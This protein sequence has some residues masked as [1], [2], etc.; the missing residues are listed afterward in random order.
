MNYVGLEDICLLILILVCLIVEH[1]IKSYN[2]KSIQF[3]SSGAWRTTDETPIKTT[4]YVTR[5][6]GYHQNLYFQVIWLYFLHKLRIFIG[7]KY[8]TFLILIVL[9]LNNI[10]I[11]MIF[12]Q[13]T[14]FNFFYILSTIKNL[15]AT[16][17][18]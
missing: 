8:P 15:L 5:E 14:L 10:I 17:K 12:T 16:I 4:G 3:T 1:Y 2:N 13:K 7:P 18:G 9:V 11:I 6:I